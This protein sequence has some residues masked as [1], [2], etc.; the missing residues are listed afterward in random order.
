MKALYLT[1]SI[2]FTA[3]ILILAFENIGAQCSNMN[4][5]FFPLR[6]NPTIV[7]LGIAVIGIITGLFYHAFI[8]RVLAG[9]AEDEEDVF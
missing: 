1:L 2:I 3:L 9:P 6:Q 8:I 5:F 7:F 4:F